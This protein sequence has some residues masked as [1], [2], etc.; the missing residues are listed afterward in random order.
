MA[1]TRTE[2]LVAATRSVES[3]WHGGY[4]CTVE[5][6]P[7]TIQVDE[8]EEVGGANLGPQPTDLFLASVASCFTLAISYAARKRSLD[9]TELTV[10]ATGRYDGL[11]FG[12]VHVEAR[13]GA[14]EA[15]LERL[16][17]A[18]ERVCYVTNTLR[19]GVRLTTRAVVPKDGEIQ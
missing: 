16:V 5:A 18:A 4:H 7:F 15:E 6:G 1:T 14:P 13:I 8:P 17:A 9:L 12:A 19:S 3:V 2:D 10:R 11:Q